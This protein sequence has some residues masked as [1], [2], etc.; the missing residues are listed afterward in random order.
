MF[1]FEIFIL[2]LCN[3]NPNMLDYILYV[4]IMKKNEKI[5]ILAIVFA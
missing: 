2:F 4:K 1:F 3:T 5:I